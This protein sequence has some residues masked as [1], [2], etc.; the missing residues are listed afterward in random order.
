MAFVHGKN[1]RITVNA[2]DLSSF[3]DNVQWRGPVDTHDTTV[4][5]DDGHTY[6]S[7]LT[8]GSIS[9]SGNYDDGATN[10]PARVLA[11]LRGGAAVT[12]LYHPEGTGTGRAQRSMSVV[13]SDYQE[14]SV[15]DDK[16]VWSA[17]L[18]ISGSVT[19]TD[20]A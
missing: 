14:E 9:M 18:Q 19:L 12:A 3:T 10:T 16:V 8:D 15:A 4:F 1:S 20:Q 6:L 11:P 7:G 13:V 5:G 17:E 2:V